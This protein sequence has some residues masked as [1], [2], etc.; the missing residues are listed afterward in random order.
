MPARAVRRRSAVARDH[1]ESTLFVRPARTVAGQAG[2]D[3]AHD[4]A[5]DAMTGPRARQKLSAIIACYRDAPAVPIMH[6][7]LTATFIKLG[8]DYEIIFVNDN[9]PDDAREVLRSEEHTSE[10]QSLRHL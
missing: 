3:R 10:L 4:P 5:A 2:R 6:E 7:R 9:S 8:V 1:G